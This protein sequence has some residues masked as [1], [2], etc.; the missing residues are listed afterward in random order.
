MQTEVE[1]E[2][3]KKYIKLAKYNADLFSKDKHTTVGAIIL[4]NDFTQIL[5]TGINGFPRKMNDTIEERWERPTKYKYVCHAEANAI[6]N[7]AMTGTAIKNSVMTVT[8][9]PCSSC[10]KLIIQAGIRKIYTLEPNYDS[11][12]WGEDAKISEEMLEEVDIDVI[13]FKEL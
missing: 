6:A 3:A 7:A 10:T 9:F 11:E 5:A 4:S 8:K 12:V 1:I 2:K 13:K